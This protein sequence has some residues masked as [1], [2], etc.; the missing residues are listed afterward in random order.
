MTRSFMQSRCWPAAFLLL[1]FIAFGNPALAEDALFWNTNANRVTAD[2]RS[3]ELFRVLQGI[4]ASTGWKVFVGP[5]TAHRVSTKFNN[6]PPGEALHLL[7][8][9]V[10]FAFMPET[11]GKPRLYVFRTSAG[12]ATQLMQPARLGAKS[13]VVAKKMPGEL[14]VR[15]KPGAKIEDIAKALGARVI[16]QIDGLNAYRLKFDDETATET[17]RAQLAGNSDVASVEDNFQIDRPMTPREAPVAGPPTPHL[18]VKPPNGTDRVIV[19]VVDTASQTIGNGLDAFVLKQM[20]VAGDPA[21]D[22]NMPSH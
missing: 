7:L 12:H 17:A 10:N 8:G 3:T 14:V 13:E 20:Y 2:I 16:G 18:E 5:E 19:G 22:P 21:L 6:L 1:V 11:N 15:L 4:S 9:N